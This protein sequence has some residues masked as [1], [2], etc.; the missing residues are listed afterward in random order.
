MKEKKA[1]VPIN[2]NDR[3]SLRTRMS[4]K[5]FYD[6]VKSLNKEQKKSC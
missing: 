3:V 5:K 4:P 6:I 1:K 2:P